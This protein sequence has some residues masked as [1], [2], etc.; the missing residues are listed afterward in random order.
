MTEEDARVPDLLLE[1]AFG[2]LMFTA[3]PTVGPRINGQIVDSTVE[4]ANV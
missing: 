4:Q 3:T 2:L 1:T